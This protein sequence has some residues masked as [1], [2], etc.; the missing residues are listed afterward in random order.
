MRGA[1]MVSTSQWLG[2]VRSFSRPHASDDDPSPRRCLGRSNTR[3]ST[4]GCRL[5][6]SRLPNAGSLNLS[7]GTTATIDTVRFATS[8]LTTATSAERLQCFKLARI[9][10][11]RRGR[12][13]HRWSG[14]TRNWSPVTLVELNPDPSQRPAAQCKVTSILTLTARSIGYRV[15]SS[16]PDARDLGRPPAA[17][18]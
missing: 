1:T 18:K 13:R 16:D 10:T 12:R 17:P 11:S 9:F 6:I 5:L 2:I 14:D 3:R 8:R 15:S 7:A 4:G